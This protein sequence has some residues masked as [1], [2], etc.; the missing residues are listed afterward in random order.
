MAVRGEL[1][2]H[3]TT[4]TEAAGSYKVRGFALEELAPMYL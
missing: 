4:I 2:M 3:C 1:D